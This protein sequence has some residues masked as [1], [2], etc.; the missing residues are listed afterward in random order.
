MLSG[1]YLKPLLG[2]LLGASIGILYA[3][4]TRCSTGACPLT[5]NAWTAGLF[6]A[7]VGLFLTINASGTQAPRADKNN[8][9]ADRSTAP[10]AAH[11]EQ[12]EGDVSVV[13][14]IESEA[15]FDSQVLR[16]SK[17]VLVDFYATWCGPCRML[18][19][20]M[21][22][23]AGEL[24]GRAE[25][26]KVDVDK[27]GSIAERYR[28]MGVPTVIVFDQGRPVQTL[29]GVHSKADYLAALNQTVP[30]QRS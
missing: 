4:F 11:S 24:T 7:A 21:N 28:I 19:P 9:A 25:V 15:D 2:V 3:R 18:E 5:G 17:P 12:K 8:V 29:V 16:S 13:R 27:V 1:F 10:A 20:T 14:H 22:Q 6:G 23:L 30:Q 26:V